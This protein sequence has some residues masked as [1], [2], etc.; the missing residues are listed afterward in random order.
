MTKIRQWLLENAVFRLFIFEPRFRWA[1]L[2]LI[3]CFLMV[4]LSLP[5][6][7]T[8]SP[9]GVTPVAKISGLDWVQCWALKRSAKRAEQ[10]RDWPA[11][12]RS[13]EVALANDFGDLEAVRGFLRTCQKVHSMDQR[14]KNSAAY[15]AFWLPKLAGDDSA[16]VLL[17]ATVLQKAG[18]PSPALSILNDSFSHGTEAGRLKLQLLFEAGSYSK[19]AKEF[20]LLSAEEKELLGPIG[21]GWMAGWGPK[22]ERPAAHR[23]LKDFVIQG[24]PDGLAARVLLA[25]AVA[26]EDPPDCELALEA[27]QRMG[28]DRLRDAV[29]YWSLL[30]RL[31]EVQRAARLANDS[32]HTP[33]SLEDVH[34][35]SRFLADTGSHKECIGFLKRCVDFFPASRD[36]WM[37]L[38]SACE[39]SGDWGSLQ[40]VANRLRYEAA[41]EGAEALGHFLEGKSYFG[42]GLEKSAE[43]CFSKAVLTEHDPERALQLSRRLQAARQPHIVLMGLRQHEA[44]LSSRSDYWHVF[45]EASLA[46]KDAEGVLHASRQLHELNPNDFGSK[47]RYAAALLINRRDSG[48]AVA[49]TFALLL[50]TP[51]AP[52]T[53]LVHAM[54]LLQNARTAEAAEMVG[55]ID[56]RQLRAE[57]LPAYFLARFESEVMTGR[58]ESARS[59]YSSIDRLRLF[60]P[61][62]RWLK[63]RSSELPTKLSSKSDL[64]DPIASVAVTLPSHF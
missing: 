9:P 31:G 62:V 10:A 4:G 22:H 21:W 19:F 11:A 46:V 18:F 26:L 32:A 15:Y 23:R 48:Q 33:A 41:F 63:A 38:A 5:R 16:D 7:W 57:D 50:A 8:T 14:T 35:M 52:E 54:A 28:A 17:R 39:S 20:E 44:A 36:I 64:F 24:S 56:F 40:E 13:W 27:L 49:L 34:A 1:A 25:V 59:A 12:L 47:H 53:Q 37:Q 55:R 3:G 30:A 58:F 43:T 61:Q 42:M 51:D 6:L 29:K 45:F 2:L 60:P